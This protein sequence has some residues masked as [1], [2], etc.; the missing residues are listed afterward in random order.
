MSY[1]SINAYHAPSVCKYQMEI[2]LLLDSEARPPKS[3]VLVL[4]WDSV[5]NRNGLA[6]AAQRSS[7]HHQSPSAILS[8]RP[9]PTILN[10]LYTVFDGYHTFFD[11]RIAA[12]DALTY[13]PGLRTG[14]AE[15]KRR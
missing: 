6:L 9:L 3:A 7:I 10:A 1:L 14:V 15:M 5:L 2:I 13:D 8:G 11:T 4:E 12:L